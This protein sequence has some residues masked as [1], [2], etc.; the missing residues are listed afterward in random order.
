MIFFIILTILFLIWLLTLI[1]C[2]SSLEIEINKLWFDSNNKKH[3]KLEDYLF[4]IRIKVL[5]KV[6]WFKTKFNKEK[7]KKIES[8]K[9]FKSKI[10]NKINEYEHIRDVL[11]KN[12]KSI[13]KKENIKYFKEINIELKK[14]NLYMQVGTSSTFLT[15]FTVAAFS[16]I[17]STILAISIKQYDES[18]Y[19]YKIIPEYEDKPV[20]KLKLNCIIS[21]RIVHIINVICM[22]IKKRREEYDERT[23]DRRA[24]VCSN[25]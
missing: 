8:S 3:H 10:F 1:I 25:D 14:I 4:Y 19:N 24:Y 11:L 15:P 18:K 20:I 9:I 22:L 13:L 17:I 12:K 2:L 7:M 6:T 23:S 16:S 5:G 21:I